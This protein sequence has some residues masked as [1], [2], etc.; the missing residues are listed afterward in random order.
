MKK[1]ISHFE[2]GE[3][4]D[5]LKGTNGASINFICRRGGGGGSPNAYVDKQILFQAVYLKKFKI[6]SDMLNS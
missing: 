4:Q 1:L 5:S 6:F 3:D 2:N